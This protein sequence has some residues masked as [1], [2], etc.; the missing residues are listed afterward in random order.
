MWL[1]YGDKRDSGVPDAVI[2]SG[3]RDRMLERVRGAVEDLGRLAQ[4]ALAVDGLTLMDEL[5]VREGS[6][7]GIPSPAPRG[8]RERALRDER[9]GPADRSATAH[10][11]GL[12]ADGLKRRDLKVPRD[13]R[14]C[15]QAAR[16]PR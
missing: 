9:A 6:R 4:P 8:D 5:G 2:T 16:P 13:R 11:F 10:A 1:R 15:S 12:S 7:G 14:P 3:E